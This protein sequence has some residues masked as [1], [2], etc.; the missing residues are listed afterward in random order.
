MRTARVGVYF[1]LAAN[2][3][4]QHVGFADI[5][6]QQ[7]PPRS[8]AAL[9]TGSLPP[10]ERSPQTGGLR[11]LLSGS[12]DLPGKISYR[13]VPLANQPIETPSSA[14][15]IPPGAYEIVLFT[16]EQESFRRKILAFAE[17]ESE[18]KIAYQK[19]QGFSLQQSLDLPA[20]KFAKNQPN[21]LEDAREPLRFLSQI[22][23][24]SGEIGLLTVE[25][26]TDSGGHESNNIALT[27]A[28]ADEIRAFLHTQGVPLRRLKGQGLG[29][30]QPVASNEGPGGRLKNRRV[31]FLIEAVDQPVS[32][33]KL[34]QESS[35][36]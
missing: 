13:L 8:I 34:G 11:L 27:Q 16:N 10:Q 2:L 14:R 7:P 36:F 22:L 19:E 6:Y 26:H 3:S 31:V 35:R 5:P 1:C 23:Q 24:H 29:S 20:I 21:L 25:V 30:S 15:G 4:Y 17:I 12:R 28:R 18:I 9:V 32:S 33:V